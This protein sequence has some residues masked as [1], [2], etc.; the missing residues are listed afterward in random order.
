MDRS[1]NNMCYLILTWLAALQRRHRRPMSMCSDGQYNGTH[2]RFTSVNT[3]TRKE[4]RGLFIMAAEYSTQLVVIHACTSLKQVPCN[5]GICTQCTSLRIHTHTHTH[6]STTLS[7]A[8]THVAAVP[9]AT[10][11]GSGPVNRHVDS[12]LAYVCVV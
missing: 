3:Y 5:F 2:S 6:T 9:L 10:S 8:C 12:M 1:S 7:N 4:T 11:C